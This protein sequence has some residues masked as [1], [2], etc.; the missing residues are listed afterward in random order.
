MKYTSSVERPISIISKQHSNLKKMSMR[1]TVMSWWISVGFNHYLMRSIQ[2]CCVLSAI[3][4][5]AQLGKTWSIFILPTPHPTD[6]MWLLCR[7]LVFSGSV[8]S[9]RMEEASA[10]TTTKCCFRVVQL[11]T[12]ALAKKPNNNSINTATN[13]SMM[14]CDCLPLLLFN[15]ASNWAAQSVAHLQLNAAEWQSR[16]KWTQA[17]ISKCQYP[18]VI[19]DTAAWELL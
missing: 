3:R 12:T 5:S 7:V 11:R 14:K 17:D 10:A 6:N 15:W 19:E 18:D 9:V 1:H 4:A 13:S 2:T 8:S 16:T